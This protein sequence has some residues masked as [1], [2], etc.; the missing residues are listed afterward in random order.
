[1][2]L[3]PCHLTFCLLVI[4]AGCADVS[5]LFRKAPVAGGAPSAPAPLPSPETVAQPA[6]FH[7]RALNYEKNGDLQLALFFWK[8][9]AKL[10]P[11]DKEVAGRI[12]SIEIAIERESRKHFEEGVRLF[13][14]GARKAAQTEFLIALRY[15]PDHEEA[16]HYLKNRLHGESYISY[17]VV[18]GDTFSTIA[19]KLYRDPQKGLLIAALLGVTPK[20][21]PAPGSV[22]LLPRVSGKLKRPT[23][24][25]QQ[26]TEN[27]QAL[28]ADEQFE[29]A[30]AVLDKVLQQEPGNSAARELADQA[31]YEAG[32]RLKLQRR[33]L[34]ALREF[35]KVS[36][37]Y[38]DTEVYVAVIHK[39]LEKDAETHYRRGVKH[40][41][42]E[43]LE[44]AIAEW[45]KTLMLNPGHQKAPQDIE[46]ARD[47]L[48][49]LNTVEPQPPTN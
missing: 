22:L 13:K 6:P 49:K 42:N 23:I 20:A 21:K 4:I 18:A 16:L 2:K 27:A 26:E 14:E 34:D 46:N 28:L 25:T 3:R 37:G 9:V 48:K 45:E 39:Q 8:V 33:Y 41:V 38:R 40:F 36:P 17:Q 29:A 24:N 1:M 30:A 15:N 35:E 47:L 5:T 7:V 43:D 31:H 11:E 32:R 44:K 10:N 19:E 12:D